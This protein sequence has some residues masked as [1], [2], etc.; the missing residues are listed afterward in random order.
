MTAEFSASKKQNSS[1][2]IIKSKIFI[3]CSPLALSVV[4]DVKQNFA[5]I[6][7]VSYCTTACKEKVTG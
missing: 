7:C 6:C 1:Q 5:S 4:Y 2:S 3:S